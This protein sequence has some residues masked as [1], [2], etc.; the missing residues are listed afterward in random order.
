VEQG[1]WEA[2]AQRELGLQ[3]STHAVQHPKPCTSVLH[4]RMDTHINTPETVHICLAHA[5]EH[6]HK[7]THLVAHV[8][9]GAQGEAEGER[10]VV[11]HKVAHIL[12]QEVARP[13]APGTAQDDGQQVRRPEAGAMVA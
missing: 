5:H 1:G 13:A 10:L 7:H 11:G 6:T 2:V 4:M 8:Q 12:K 9:Q 3:G